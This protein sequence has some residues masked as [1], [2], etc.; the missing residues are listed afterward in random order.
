MIQQESRLLVADNSGAKEVLCVRVLGGT[1]HRYA[2]IGDVIVVTVK[3]HSRQRHQEGTISRPL[4]YAQKE[5][6]R[7]TGLTSVSMTMLASSEP[8]RRTPRHPYF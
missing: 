2:T 4:W 7:R 8:G 5:I 6:R 3:G 1:H